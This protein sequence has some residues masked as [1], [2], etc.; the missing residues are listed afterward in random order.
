MGLHAGELLGLELP[1][2]DKRLFA[3][4]ETDG[5][6]ADAVSV[7]TG[8][9]LGHRTLRLVDRGKIAATFVDTATGAAVRVWPDAGARSR[10]RELVPA[11]HDR[12]HAQLEGYQV[13]LVSELLRSEPVRLTIDL[14]A[15]R[16]R[17]GRRVACAGCGEEVINEREVVASGRSYCR[18]CAGDAYF[19][20]VLGPRPDREG[21]EHED[22]RHRAVAE[23]VAAG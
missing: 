13:M 1:R 4:V 14:D 2:T 6:L 9:A 5:C 15:I 20:P 22:A 10:A 16:S 18:D 17:P 11:A 19:V 21:V 7:A 12:W 23:G 3:L 8:C